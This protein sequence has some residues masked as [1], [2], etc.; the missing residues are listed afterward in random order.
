[1]D[2]A[3]LQ[4][5]ASADQLLMRAAEVNPEPN[6]AGMRAVRRARVGWLPLHRLAIH[7]QRPVS[8]ITSPEIRPSTELP[9]AQQRPFARL[10]S[11]ERA[12]AG[13]DPT[14]L[15]DG[16]GFEGEVGRSPA[17]STSSSATESALRPEATPIIILSPRFS[18]SPEPPALQLQDVVQR[19][20]LLSDFLEARRN[21]VE[22]YGSALAIPLASRDLD[23]YAEV[24]QW[25]DSQLED[26]L[27]RLSRSV[28]DYAPEDLEAARNLNS[29]MEGG[30]GQITEEQRRE[31]DATLQETRRAQQE[32][33][34]TE[35]RLEQERAQAEVEEEADQQA[36]FV[37]SLRAGQ[38]SRSRRRRRLPLSFEAQDQQAEEDALAF[39]EFLQDE[40]DRQE[41]SA[42]SRPSW[43]FPAPLDLPRRRSFEPA[44]AD[45]GEEELWAA[46][47]GPP[48]PFGEEQQRTGQR[49]WRVSS[50]AL[51]ERL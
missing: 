10:I 49:L 19:L 25:T 28:R 39:D 9:A 8:P 22:F 27:A 46:G 7:L 14:A 47:W 31:F 4:R 17:R 29:A 37:T 33:R 5:R 34:E 21:R 51:D 41:A 13:M 15:A 35:E 32:A 36:L 26:E 1:M 45:E 42:P 18:P 6:D 30:G 2:I 40:L 38:S 50:S 48:L 20:D 44:M 24:Q 3:Q 16:A 23:D 43:T 11:S 12:R